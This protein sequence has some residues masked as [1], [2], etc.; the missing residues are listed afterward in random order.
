MKLNTDYVRGYSYVTSDEQKKLDQIQKSIEEKTSMLD[1][2]DIETCIS[3]QE[4]DRIKKIAKQIREKYQVA[5]VIGIGGSYLG[6][7]AVI[8]S[9]SPYFAK[10][11]ETEVLFAGYQLSSTYLTELLQYIEDKEV[12]LVVISKSGGTLE[13]AISFEVLKNYLKTK[14]SSYSERIFVIT[15][16][17]SGVLRREAQEE[18]YVSFE[19]PKN[20]G[21]RY[22][23]LSA[24]GLLPIAISGID[25]DKLLKGASSMRDC[26]KETS[27][28]ATIRD[29]LEYV[30]KN[31]E[32]VT[33][34]E[35]K[36]TSLAMWYQQ[37]F[38]ETQGKNHK[39]ILP[40]VNPNTTNLHSVGQYLQE[41]TRNVFETVIRIKK[42]DDL[43]LDKYKIDMHELNNLVVEQV[44]KAHLKGDTPSI[45]LELE[46]LTPYY[47]GQL[48]YFLE[49]TAAIGG[50]LLDVD[51]FDQPGVEEYKQLV[52]EKLEEL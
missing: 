26:F 4:K 46:E 17:D 13:P 14:T 29:R 37:L 47:L 39:G 31:V 25:I 22:S 49:M 27:M 41:G 9:L 15:D 24:V 43:F 38:A 1:W 36:L 10:N 35:E 51:P 12:C 40:V 34:Y 23:V 11:K 50:Y 44:A 45:I 48:I 20:I 2:I 5:I 42:S 6:S 32:M 33:I 3:K 28:L 18:G 7:K 52:N 21:G 30:G 19:V 16:K 8:E